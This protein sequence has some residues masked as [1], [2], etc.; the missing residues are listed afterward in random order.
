MQ[1]RVMLVGGPDV[2]SRIDLMRRL[3]RHFDLAA[4]G[5]DTTRRAQ[6]A[7]SGFAY[8]PYRLSRGTRPGTDVRSVAQLC[9]IF[10]RDRPDIVHTFDTKPCVL[11]RIAAAA[12]RVP[13]IV[14]TLPGLGSLY[15]ANGT[16]RSVIR[17][18]YEKLQAAA[19]RVSDVTIFQNTDDRDEFVRRGVVPLS[20]TMLLPGSGVC[21]ERFDRSS[22]SQPARRDLRA[23]LGIPEDAVLVTMVSRVIRSKGVMEFAEAA[24]TVTAQLPQT[25]FLLVGSEDRGSGSHLTADDATLLENRVIWTRHR[26]DIDVVLAAS[27]IFV[28]PTR[29]REGLPRVLLEAAAMQLPLVTTRMPGC[30]ELVEGGVHGLLVPAG[31]AHWLALAIST[32][33]GNAAMRARMGRAARDRVLGRFDLTSIAERTASLYLSLLAR[34]GRKRAAAPPPKTARAGAARSHQ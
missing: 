3:S 1:P 7:A 19:S 15:S 5:S 11:G 21:T 25:R 16:D 14:G 9:R 8:H 34:Q 26:R 6:F 22:V 17:R 30:R 10:H 20:Q 18:L 29:Y 24:R 31:E 12:A 27:D 33:V 4:V 28:L 13:T 2:D 32:L 23:S